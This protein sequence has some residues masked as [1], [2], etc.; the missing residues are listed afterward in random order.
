MLKFFILLALTIVI[1]MQTV[2]SYC[3]VTKTTIFQISVIIPEHVMANNNHS[4]TPISKNTY[5][6][7]QTQTVIRNNKS[8]RLTSIV[9]P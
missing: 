8:I 6:L 7:V 2:P 4:V 1:L 9:V 5:Q 3:G